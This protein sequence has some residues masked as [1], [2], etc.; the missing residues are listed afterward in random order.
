MGRLILLVGL[1]VV[2]LGALI[3]FEVPMDWIGTLPGDFSLHWKGVL[4]F[5]LITSSLVFSLALAVF[6]FIFARN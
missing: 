3:T 6:L 1:T 5:V 4:V 2:I